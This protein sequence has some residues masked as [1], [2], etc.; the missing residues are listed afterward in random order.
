MSFELNNTERTYLGLELVQENWEKIIL[1]GD[2][3]RPDSILYFDNNTIKKQVIST[4]LLYA[5]IKYNEETKDREFILPKT[6]RGKPKKLTS[7]T[8][9]SKTPVGTYF[10]FDTNGIIIGNHTTQNTFYSTYFE[11]IK[12]KGISDLKKWLTGLIKNSTSIDLKEIEK[13]STK[14]RKRIKLKEG[15]F[16]VF[17]VDRRNYSFGRLICDLRPLRKDSDF[18][19]NK[20][21]GIMNLMTQPLVIKI[22]HHISPTREV[23]LDKLKTLKSI[24][25]QYLMDNALFYGDYEI[26]GNQPLSSSEYDFPISYS[27]SIHYNDFDTVYLQYGM[28]YKETSI[29]KYNKH[30]TIEN[31]DKNAKSWEKVLKS[32]PYRVESI[33]TT[34]HF[35]KKILEDCIQTNSNE[36]YWDF[37]FYGLESDLRNTKNKKV[38]DEIFEFF[39]L[40]PN[41]TYFEN[42][43]KSRLE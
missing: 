25:A 26:I 1:K 32:N 43:N 15:D 27:K 18:K 6:K 2:T 20:N 19:R 41:A 33:S 38:K 34:L 17:K 3:Y 24:P 5:E 28:I 42:L 11:N 8:L 9:E 14:K 22:Y 16:F 39:G 21:Y 10:S 37:D 29:K 13:F 4:D 35:N 12:F 36:P 23:D 31:P 30:L 40:N 7:A